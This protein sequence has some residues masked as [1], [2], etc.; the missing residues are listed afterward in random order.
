MCRKKENTFVERKD[1]RKKTFMA[2]KRL[3]K[4]TICRK[5]EKHSQREK[6]KKDNVYRK[7]RR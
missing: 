5:K 4:E 7:K 3:Q 1:E 2:G 6:M